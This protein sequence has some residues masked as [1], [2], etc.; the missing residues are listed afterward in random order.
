MMAV[1]V[2]TTAWAMLNQMVMVR[3]A[4]ALFMSCESQFN[5]ADVH[6]PHTDFSSWRPLAS[7][8]KHG[9]IPQHLFLVCEAR[10]KALSA[11]YGRWSCTALDQGDSCSKS[12]RQCSL[13]RI[14]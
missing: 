4:R 8:F 9:C 10:C 3:L 2:L 1:D 14:R 13:R 7:R 11:L 12:L 5:S 6:F